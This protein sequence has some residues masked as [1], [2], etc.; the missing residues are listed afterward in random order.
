MNEV[1]EAGSNG[2][3]KTL[4]LL[5]EELEFED[6]NYGELSLSIKWIYDEATAEE[7]KK[8]GKKSLFRRMTSILRPP[9][10]TKV[11]PLTPK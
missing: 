6:N 3:V 1:A 8:S 2:L 7:A 4:I 11:S 10:P 9:K 5:G